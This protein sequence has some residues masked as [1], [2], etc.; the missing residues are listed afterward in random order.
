MIFHAVKRSIRMSEGRKSWGAIFF[1]IKDCCLETEDLLLAR[2]TDVAREME[3]ESFM[4]LRPYL[5][6]S[7]SFEYA[8]SLGNVGRKRL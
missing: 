5:G 3:T 4:S 7:K 6:Q 2:E 8:S 1:L